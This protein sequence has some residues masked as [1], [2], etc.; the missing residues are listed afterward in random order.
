MLFHF[1]YGISNPEFGS[2]GGSAAYQNWVE[3]IE[4]HNLELNSQS[5]SVQATTR[6][7][8]ILRV[9]KEKFSERLVYHEQFPMLVPAEGEGELWGIASS[10]DQVNQMI[11]PD[12]DKPMDNRRGHVYLLYKISVEGSKDWRA[13]LDFL[14]QRDMLERESP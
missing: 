5:S 6:F 1:P 3:A 7:W 12:P 14:A 11:T 10:L 13:L 9:R 4:K 8:L 2:G